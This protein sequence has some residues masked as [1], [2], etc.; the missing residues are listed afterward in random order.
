MDSHKRRRRLLGSTG[1]MGSNMRALAKVLRTLRDM[2]ADDMDFILGGSSRGNLRRSIDDLYR[3]VAEQVQVP[4]IKGGSMPIHF[5]NIAKL[6]SVMVEEEADGG[7]TKQLLALPRSS[8]EEPW[9]LIVYGDEI[10]P[11]NVVHP[12][13]ARKSY[14]IAF[15]VREFGP[16]TITHTDAWFPWSVI[17]HTE[18]LKIKG[19]VSTVYRYVLRHLFLTLKSRD[20]MDCGPRLGTVYLGLSNLIMDGD[21]VHLTYHVFASGALLP[22]TCLNLFNGA[23]PQGSP[24]APPGV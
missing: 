5:I 14:G 9:H 20:G 1:L 16:D 2:S 21:A 10:T 19:G 4:L 15:T 18:Y 6:W 12:D 22:C 13:N 11:G 7:Y 3:Q 17:R 23:G 8:R 24:H